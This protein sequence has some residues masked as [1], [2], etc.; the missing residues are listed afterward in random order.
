MGRNKIKIEKI[1]N[2]R[3]RQVIIFFNLVGD[4]L[5]KEKGST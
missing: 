4:F 2:E 1:M 3:N 5:Q